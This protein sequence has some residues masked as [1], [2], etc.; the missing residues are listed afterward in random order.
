MKP[1]SLRRFSIFFVT[2]R[3]SGG[4]G[5][6]GGG[7]VV[8][9]LVDGLWLECSNSIARENRERSPPPQKKNNLFLFFVFFEFLWSIFFLVF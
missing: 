8:D 7:L 6:S 4:D 5:A 3:G 2:A 1:P 9:V